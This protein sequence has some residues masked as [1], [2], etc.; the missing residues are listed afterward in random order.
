VASVIDDPALVIA[1]YPG[2]DS[3]GAPDC[4]ALIE[5]GLRT[6]P[7]SGELWLAKAAALLKARRVDNSLFEA[8]RM[9]YRTSRKEGWV[10]SGRVLLG[11][12]LYPVLPPDLAKDVDGDL[13][14]VIQYDQFSGVLTTAYTAENSLRK[15]AQ[16]ALDRLSPAQLGKFVELVRWKAAGH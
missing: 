15:A 6:A 3:A 16:P 2:C 11:L 12:R 8:L 5:D 7:Y 14:L 13:A 9:S 10:A 4:L 1:R